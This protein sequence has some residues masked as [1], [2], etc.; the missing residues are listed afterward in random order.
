MQED[1]SHSRH[2]GHA[3]KQPAFRAIVPHRDVLKQPVITSTPLCLCCSTVWPSHSQVG[4]TISAAEVQLLQEAMAEEAVAAV[5][6]TGA[7]CAP[8]TSSSSGGGI[9]GTIPPALP[10]KGYIDARALLQQLTAAVE[11]AAAAE[12][13]P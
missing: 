1:T 13:A 3:Y 8:A 4:C 11:A 9:A 6:A 7:A 12:V 5:A 2:P 10:R